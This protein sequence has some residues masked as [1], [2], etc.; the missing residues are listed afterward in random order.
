VSLFGVTISLL[1][2]CERFR[3]MP[4]HVEAADISFEVFVDGLRA[5]GLIAFHHRVG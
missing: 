3:I 2:G 1:S 4:E 5:P